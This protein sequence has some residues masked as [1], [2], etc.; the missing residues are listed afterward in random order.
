MDSPNPKLDIESIEIRTILDMLSIT[1]FDD[2][3]SITNNGI[4]YKLGNDSKI[5]SKIYELVIIEK[6]KT[7]LS[8]KGFN[9]ID[10]DI[11]NKYPDFII[12]SKIHEETYY[13][14]DIKSSYLKTKSKVNGFTLGTYKGYFTNRD[15][16]KSIVKPYKNFNK[17]FCVC[18][19]YDRIQNL[20]PVKHIIIREKWEIASNTPGSG[21]TCNIGSIKLLSELLDNKCYFDS[22]NDFNKFWL[23]Y[24]C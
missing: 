8:S 2:E 18:V 21:N 19:I 23:N 17:H 11:Q 10:N 7:L 15:S 20:I 13:A 4:S 1:E 16:M 6:L 14:I 22:E 5:I 3:F 24:K 12:I 9:Y